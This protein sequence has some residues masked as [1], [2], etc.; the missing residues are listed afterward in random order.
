[1]G[2]WSDDLFDE[3]ATRVGP[4]AD[5]TELAALLK[6][7]GT[8]IELM[9]GRA[10]A[11]SESRTTLFNTCGL[12]FVDIPDLQVGGHTASVTVW[13]LPDPVNSHVATVLQVAEFDALPERAMP[14]GEALWAAGHFVAAVSRAG[15]FS[16]DLLL[17][18]LRRSFKSEEDRIEFLKLLMDPNYRVSVP[19]AAGVRGGWWFQITRR[20][21]WVTE[22]T[23]D[24]QRLLA[25]LIDGTDG[26]RALAG[27]EPMLI[28][29]RITSH[30]ANWAFS[31]RIW[32]KVNCVPK[33]PWRLLARGIHGYGIPVIT[34]DDESSAEET[35]SQLLLLAHW[36]GYLGADEPGLAEAIARGYPSAVKRIQRGTNMP[37]SRSAAALLLEGLL[38]PG[39]DPALGAESARR[40]VNRKAQI[41]IRAHRRVERAGRHPW[42][43]HGVSERYY[44]KLLKR[45]APR[46][47]DR[48][49]VDDDIHQSIRAYVAH[50]QQ[51][52]D[53]HA[54]AME[55]LQARG[56]T[57]AA[58]RKWLQRHA[59]DEIRSAWPRRR[60][61][62]GETG[63]RLGAPSS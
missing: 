63:V 9:A 58:A 5:R 59:M 55:L 50:R 53:R 25:P 29:A 24:E 51:R 27:V 30:P 31:A 56:F 52:V 20:L 57:S 38:H 18:W 22:D 1:M 26:V 28:L 14:V 23:P 35:A 6:R 37:D 33:R 49:Q 47:G 62:R 48:Y 54:V 4:K 8:E 45:F 60:A 15:R 39:F 13:P 16:R 43:Q 21:V 32:P 41:A 42:E 19:I 44:Y 3:V 36:H 46:V 7:A 12:P 2:H 10:F 17:G 11:L 40:Y 34:I 61:S